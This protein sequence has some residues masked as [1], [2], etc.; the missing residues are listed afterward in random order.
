[1]SGIGSRQ[2]FDAVKFQVLWARVLNIADEMAATLVKTAFSHV[3]RDNQDYACA[4][5]DSVGNML[6]QSTQ[7]TPGQIGAMPR[8]LQDFLKVYPAASL[9]PGDVLITNDPWLGSGHTPDIFIAT[10]AF[11]GGR[12]IGFAIS[13]AHHID[14]GGRMASPD[15]RDVYEEGIII[16][17]TK[18]YR[19]GQSNDDIF[20]IIC[21]N[22]RM[23][24][25]VVGDLRAQLAANHLG[26][27]RMARLMED[28]QLGSLT[29]LAEA[30]IAHTEASM[31]TAIAG[32]PAGTYTN[33]VQLE[34]RGR[35]GRPLEIVVRIEVE[36]GDIHV[37][38]TG[39]SAQVDLPINSV[40]NITQAYV[41]F[42][43]KCALH[44][45]IPN[46]TGSFRPIRITVPEGTI[47]SAVFPAP[48]MWRTTVVYFVVEAIFGALARAIP[49]RVMAPSGTYPLWGGMYA[50]KLRDGRSF[51]FHF[52]AQGG[53]GALEARDGLST[54]VFPPN[55]ANTSVEQMEHEAPLVC[56]RKELVPDSGG[57][58]RRRGGLGQEVVLRNMSGNNI[59][60]SI[61]GGRLKAGAPGL[62]GGHRGRRGVIRQNDAAAFERSQ[63][64][65]LKDNDTIHLSYPG[66]GGIGHPA[67]RA[68][69][70][71]LADVER[72]FVSREAAQE[73]YGVAF[74]DDG[75]RID[76]A[77]TARRRAA[78]LLAA[79]ARA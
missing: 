50:G 64:V 20:N 3:V 39:T 40:Y 18:L 63:Q 74:S 29:D 47:L 13:S 49:D 45:H 77:L 66:G 67:E 12:L 48:C 24:D 14:I 69:A 32:V 72:G 75:T 8:V 53:Q 71:V 38:F 79:A 61:V 6:A 76:P 36:G 54:T 7:C 15:A 57:P 58:G 33:R 59:V 78:L 52:N 65:V 46:N 42:P 34:D 19:A 41:L 31:R 51:V 44:P 37:D 16:P 25:K 27:G 17:I 55:V 1:M 35:D 73:I 26:A 5:Y 56:E 62:A 70:D 23:A 9:E 28:F 21:R 10:P 2:R 11:L 22:V 4:I 60:A 43:I 68:I 30:I